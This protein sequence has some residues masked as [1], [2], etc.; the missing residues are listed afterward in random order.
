MIAIC[1]NNNNNTKKYDIAKISVNLALLSGDHFSLFGKCFV[2][3]LLLLLLLLYQLLLLFCCWRRAQ[4]L[5]LVRS[6][7]TYKTHNEMFSRQLTHNAYCTHAI[8]VFFTS[9]FSF[10]SFSSHVICT[11]IITKHTLTQWIQ[12]RSLLPP[13]YRFY[14]SYVSTKTTAGNVNLAQMYNHMHSHLYTHN[15]IYIYILTRCS[16]CKSAAN[17]W[18][19][20]KREWD[21]S[22]K[23]AH[24]VK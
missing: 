20:T 9:F 7:G 17:R 8:I 15:Y 21:R 24:Q 4:M 22:S 11:I 18:S 6:T 14:D 12:E 5:W 10:F 16:F 13:P 2:Y 19:R 3:L 23:Q 1:N